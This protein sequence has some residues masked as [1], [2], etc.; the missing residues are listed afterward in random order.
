MT[1]QLGSAVLL[2]VVWGGVWAMCLQFTRWGRWLAVRRTWLT[3]VVGVGVDLLILA[4]AL[5]LEA[6]LLVTAV[7]GAS[8]IGVIVRSLAN[9]HLEDVR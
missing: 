3:V 6:W 1:A 9:E 8:S 5:P 2:G 4:L 7:L